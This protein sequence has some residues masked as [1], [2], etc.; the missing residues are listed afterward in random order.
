MYK[1]NRKAAI[2]AIAAAGATFG[3]PAIVMAAPPKEKVL[4]VVGA[5]HAMVYFPWDLA[6]ALGYF[7]AEGIDLEI[8][9]TKGGSEAAQALASGSCD[10]SGNAIDHAIA[11]AERGKSLVMI[12]DFMNEPGVTL[13]VRPQDKN[14]FKSFKDFKGKTLG[15]TSLGSATDVIVHW[16]GKRAGLG[17]DDIKV[18]GVGGGSTMPAA[19]AGGQVDGALGNDPFATQM[20][21]SGRAVANI[22]LFTPAVV[23]ANM[24]FST[25]CF[26]GALTRADVIAKYPERTQKIV[27]ALVRAH[28][29]MAARTP[30][31]IAAAL[32]DEFRGGVAA[33]DWAAGYS[34]SR[35]AYTPNGEISLEGVKAVIETND[36]FLNTT[37]KAEPSK[38][39]DNGFVEK[40]KRGVKV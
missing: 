23:R 13:V 6:K 8:N 10:Y 30:D 35:P 28:K 27:N 37:S 15:I 22:E 12:A 31:Q 18:V 25:Y 29:Y 19:L 21:R 2:T 20:I 3:A 38:L 9:Y 7:D 26:T 33:A 24:G 34:H 40:A 5:E 16:M 39:F 17:R 36:F 1:I 14:A 11:A 32:S 4:A